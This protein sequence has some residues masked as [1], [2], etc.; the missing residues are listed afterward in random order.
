MGREIDYLVVHERFR[1]GR[2]TVVDEAAMKPHRPVRLRVPGA[3]PGG[4]VTEL[5]R[6]RVFPT[7]R[8]IGPHL[9]VRQWE[10]EAAAAAAACSRQ[11]LDD[12]CKLWLTGY[13]EE[14]LAHFPLEEKAASAY[15]GRAQQAQRRL[16]QVPADRGCRG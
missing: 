9:A 1:Q 4:L 10:S 2:A 7:E 14:L 15:R 3:K 11:Q 5:H 13:E 6:P 16:R 12:A 8:V